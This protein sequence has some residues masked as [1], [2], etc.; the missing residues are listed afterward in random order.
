[1]SG[2]PRID[3][4]ERE[5]AR[6]DAWFDTAR[7]KALFESEVLCLRELTAE[8]ARPWLEVGVGTGRFAEALEIDV[9]V[10]PARAALA[11]A[12][13]RGV[14]VLPAVGQRLPFA[15]GEF[16]AVFVITTM[17]FAD[18]PEGLLHETARVAGNGGAVVLGFVPADSP[19]GEHYAAMGRS[20]HTFYSHARFFGV[21]E[22]EEIAG[23]AGLAV[24]RYAS[25]LFR[26]PGD[27][28]SGVE[29]P[30]DGR[31][32]EAGFVAVLC[33][34]WEPPTNAPHATIRDAV[35]E[36]DGTGHAR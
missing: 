30:R 1:M 8:L 32:D 7:G 36:P 33:R 27:E 20:G 21:D 2:S 5:A 25:T 22:L 3:L 34:A 4:F 24:E 23:S 28:R 10:D 19:W 9:G 29:M 35:R 16:G 31:H 11:C 12:E 17:C 14:R 26:G 6:Y 13:R 15:A 18:D